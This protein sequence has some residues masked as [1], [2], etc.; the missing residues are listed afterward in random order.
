MTT[1]ELKHIYRRWVDM[2]NGDSAAINE[3]VAEDFVYYQEH[4]QDVRGPQQLRTTIEGARAAFTD[5]TFRTD[6]GP[7]AEDTLVAAHN[8][9]EA[10]Y[11]GGLPGATAATGTKVSMRGMDI[12][13]IKDNKIVECWH[14]SNDLSFMLQ[15]G[16]AKMN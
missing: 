4:G 8:I 15:L 10:T 3:C 1:D 9:A 12:L 16:A 7:I 5:L 14:N 11:V 13:R 2:W 6:V